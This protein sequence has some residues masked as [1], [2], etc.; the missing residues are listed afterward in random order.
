MNRITG[1]IVIAIAALEIPAAM[2]LPGIVPEGLGFGTPKTKVFLKRKLPPLVH[3]TAGSFK[4][5]VSGRETQADLSR[6]LAAQLETE[7]MKDDSNLRAEET[8]PSIVISCQITEFAHPQPTVTQRP[9]V[10]AGKNGPKTLP[11]TRITGALTVAFQARMGNQTLAS[12]NITAKYDEEFDSSG[13]KASHGVIAT[14]SD[15]LH[16]VTGG[17]SSEDLN[18][19]TDAELRMKLLSDAVHQIAQHLVTTSE[20]VEVF[21]AKGK[22]PL[23]EG[24]KQAEA[25]LWQR[26]LETYETTPQMPK[27]TDDAY[28][29]YDI[30]VAYEAL[31]Y[32]T[33]DDKSAM[34]F[35]DEA[36]INYGKAIDSKPAEKYFLEP[37]RRIETAI[38]HYKELE[39]QKRPKLVETTVTTKSAGSAS[40]AKAAV[41]ALTNAQVI[42][43]VK[44]GMEDD[45]VVQ[46]IRGA[47]SANFD[48]STG[49]QQELA[50]NGVSSQV[51]AAMKARA[52]H[53]TV[54]AK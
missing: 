39:E 43:M 21:L 12:N 24:N 1:A 30:G 51:V 6:D 52:A 46:A 40:A 20:N 31:A 2:G 53:K 27:P 38:A 16:R 15:A 45:T 11:Y 28:R 36:A 54:A 5:K 32:S 7:L 25:G 35:L 8:A 23:D 4:V 26:A 29:L 33:E 47:H 18:P 13:N 22:K 19:P 37:Q 10:A 17:A 42:A 49:A 50:G 3:L 41:K 48:L 9:N 34:K 14:V 44:S